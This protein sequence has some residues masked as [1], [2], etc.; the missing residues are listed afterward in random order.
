[1][2]A[3]KKLIFEGVH[4]ILYFN[5][6]NSINSLNLKKRQLD[7]IKPA[8]AAT[9]CLPRFSYADILSSTLYLNMHVAVVKFR[10]KNHV[11]IFWKD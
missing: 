5:E 10:G 3:V 4:V 2:F 1:M 9:S 11:V 7:Y 8:V 6:P